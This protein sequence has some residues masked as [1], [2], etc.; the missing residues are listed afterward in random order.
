M[1]L[2]DLSTLSAPKTGHMSKF[3]LLCQAARLLGQVLRYVSSSSSTFTHDNDNDH[4]EEE[5]IQLDRTLQSMVAASLDL[6]EPDDDQ[7]SFVYSTLLALHS[8]WLYSESTNAL[9]QDR[10][11]RARGVVQQITERIRENLMARRCFL[12]RDPEG[13]APWGLFFAYHVCGFHMR[14]AREGEGDGE[15]VEVE[16][17]RSLKETFAAVDV[18]WNAAGRFLLVCLASGRLIS[19]GVYLQLLEAQE[20]LICS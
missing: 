9:D 20:V 8:P 1:N 16:V 18:R 17:V 3:A 2:N 14:A 5:G 12:G 4:E 6:E 13:M 15:E 10:A 19:V 11:Q 7:I